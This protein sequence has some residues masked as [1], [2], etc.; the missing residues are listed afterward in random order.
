MKSKAP[1]LI[2]DCFQHMY[3]SLL[4]SKELVLPW[5]AQLK[6]LLWK[7]CSYFTVLKVCK[8]R[9][10]VHM[11]CFT[12]FMAGQTRTCS[13]LVHSSFSKDFTFSFSIILAFTSI[14]FQ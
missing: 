5:I 12:A 13:I 2:F 11:N 10:R 3:A 8:A 6:E 14:L 7:C 4:M 9:A 1:I